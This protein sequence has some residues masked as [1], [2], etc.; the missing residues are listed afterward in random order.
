[1]LKFIFSAFASA[2]IILIAI[3]AVTGLFITVMANGAVIDKGF[4]WPIVATLVG[5]VIYANLFHKNGPKP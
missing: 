5:F 2:T 1:M 4:W 3:A